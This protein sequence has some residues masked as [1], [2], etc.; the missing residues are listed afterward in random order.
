MAQ[1]LGGLSKCLLSLLS[2]A[3]ADPVVQDLL[4]ANKLVRDMRR[5]SAQSLRFHSFNETMWQQ[6]VSVLWADASNRPRP[7]GSQTGGYVISL[8]NETLFG[9]GQEDDVSVMASLQSGQKSRK[10][11]VACKTCR[12][13]SYQQFST[14][15]LNFNTS[16]VG[17]R[18]VQP[19]SRLVRRAGRRHTTAHQQPSLVTCNSLST[20]QGFLSFSGKFHGR[21]LRSTANPSGES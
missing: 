1:L 16:F 19:S 4:D 17:L 2:S 6:L 12:H 7:D 3:T 11:F 20:G 18:G 21:Q 14:L 10:S 13:V 9:H 15:T 8:A 5:S